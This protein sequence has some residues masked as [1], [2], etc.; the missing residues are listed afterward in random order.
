MCRPHNTTAR[1]WRPK[2]KQLADKH[3][4]G[5]EYGSFRL[6]HHFVHG[7]AM[8]AAQR[9]SRVAEDTALVGGL[10]A[11]L[12]VWGRDAGLFAAYSLLHASRAACRILEWEE[13]AAL[14]DLLQG[15]EPLLRAPE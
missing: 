9:Y 4:R 12:E 1:H 10:A 8:A 6:T 2:E 5:D 7:S 11:A 15:V 3:G 14:E 13:P